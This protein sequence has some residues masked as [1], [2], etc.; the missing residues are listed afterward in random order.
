[1][2][3]PNLSNP[4]IKQEFE[5][6]KNIFGEN[7]AYLLWNRNGGYHLDKAPNGNSSKLFNDLLGITENKEKAL[8][9]KAKTLTNAFKDWFGNSQVTDNNGEPLLTNLT[10]ISKDNQIKSIFNSGEYNRNSDDI[11]DNEVIVKTE[12]RRQTQIDGSMYQEIISNF[13]TYFPNY[14]FYNDQQRR[15]VADLVERGKLQIT[16]SI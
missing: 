2:I 13:E 9:L 8:K 4:Q 1:M 15:I 6:L 3:C 7:L 14:S 16:C 5:E 10:F 12:N 11:Y